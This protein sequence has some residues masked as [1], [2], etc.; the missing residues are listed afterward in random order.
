M[1]GQ[2]ELQKRI[3]EQIKSGTFPRFSILAGQPGSG[4]KKLCSVI[5]TQLNASLYICPISVED[6]RKMIDTAYKVSTKIL[7]VIADADRMSLAAKNALL[8]V[9]EEPPQNAY[10]IMTLSDANNTLGTIRSRGTIYRMDSYNFD[11]LYE[12]GNQITN[13]TLHEAESDIIKNICETPGEVNMLFKNTGDSYA[14]DFFNYIEKVIDNIAEVSGAN[15]FKIGDKIALKS[16]DTDKYDLRLFWKGFMSIC[17][18][19]LDDDVFKYLSAIRITSKYLQELRI[20]GI[21]KQ[22]TFDLW[23]LDIRE[24]WV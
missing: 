4:K 16:A 23:I 8:K 20:V 11:E 18:D 22:S 5:A 9:T 7:Y 24:A 6:I 12:Y 1:I 19:R 17:A 21:N 15:S 2:V 10:F 3:R 14:I 13:Y